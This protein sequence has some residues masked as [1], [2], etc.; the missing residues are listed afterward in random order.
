MAVVLACGV[1]FAAHA[2]AGD[3]APK[4]VE[5]AWA[6]SIKPTARLEARGGLTF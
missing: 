2:Q 6:R 1:A 4:F 5:S 3:P